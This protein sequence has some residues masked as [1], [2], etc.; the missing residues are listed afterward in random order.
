MNCVATDNH[1]LAK[2]LGASETV[3][4]WYRWLVNR[5][6]VKWW[7]DDWVGVGSMG[8][9]EVIAIHTVDDDIAEL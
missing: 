8:L 7:V 5:P 2:V 9:N 6:V 4:M 3:V 1:V